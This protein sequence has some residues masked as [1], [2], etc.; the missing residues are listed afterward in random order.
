QSNTLLLTLHQ[1]EGSLQV[2]ADFAGEL[3]IAGITPILNEIKARAKEWGST[4]TLM[5]HTVSESV[6]E[7]VF[8]LG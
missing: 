4:V 6:L 3:D 2:A 7:C 1:E 5:P 8:P